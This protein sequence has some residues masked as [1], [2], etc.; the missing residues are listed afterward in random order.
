MTG[1]T[2]AH[3]CK[4][5]KRAHLRKADEIS[6]VFD[7]KCRVSS[8]HFIVLGKPNS[9]EFPRLAILVAKK[10][11]RLAVKRNYMRRVMRE[12]FRKNSANLDALDVVVRI[13]KSFN[14]QEYVA[15]NQETAAIF[16]KLVKCRA[17]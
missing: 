10:T 15:I 2:F 7:F 3:I 6:S 5:K 12:Y 13:I 14:R 17:S 9:L 4:D 11:D 8:T 1:E 16:T